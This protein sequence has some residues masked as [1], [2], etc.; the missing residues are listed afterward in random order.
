MKTVH[1]STIKAQLRKGKPFTGYIAPNKVNSFHI[2]GGWHIG[3]DVTF[4][5]IEE[6]EKIIANYYYYNCIPE[7]GMRVRFWVKS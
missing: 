3:M 4:S 7:L 5:T 2:V 1:K 6:M